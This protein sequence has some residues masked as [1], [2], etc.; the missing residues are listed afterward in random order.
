MNDFVINNGGK[1]NH[2]KLILIEDL[3]MGIK[4]NIHSRKFV[5]YAKENR[6]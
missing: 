3:N 5:K 6:G 4:N 2:K 1:Q